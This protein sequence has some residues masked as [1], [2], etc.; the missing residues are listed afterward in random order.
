MKNHI[1]KYLVPH[2]ARFSLVKA[3]TAPSTITTTEV[4]KNITQEAIRNID[5]L[6][7]M[8]AP[9]KKHAL[10]LI[11]QAL[12]AGGKDRTIR[13]VLSGL[14]P[15][16]CEV[17]SFKQPTSEELEHD[18]LWRTNLH[19]PR[20]GMIG[21]FNRS[22]YEDV[23]IA[24]VHP[25]LLALRDVPPSEIKSGEIWQQRFAA[26][27]AHEKHLSESGTIIIKFWLNISRDEQKKRLLERLDRPDRNWK[28]TEDDIEDRHYFGD[29]L[30][31]AEEAM[32]ITSTQ[33]APWYVIPAD[34]KSYTH[35]LIA[36]IIEDKMQSLNLKYPQ[37]S[38]KM[39]GDLEKMRVRLLKS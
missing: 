6:Q 30:K 31:A 27:L 32:R 12:D 25:K 16:G 5:R 21:V 7:Q 2:S 10:L 29:Y 19:L 1:A 17:T 15:A 14:N 23:L 39:K 34:I 8:F 13:T 24:R 11:F 18:F 38:L 22:Y 37:S 36:T 4:L 9:S 35:A 20:R 26:I 3:A 33:A 28:F